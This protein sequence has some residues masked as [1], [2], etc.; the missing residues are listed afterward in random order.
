MPY[1]PTTALLESAVR[2]ASANVY[3]YRLNLSRQREYQRQLEEAKQVLQQ[4]RKQLDPAGY[5]AQQQWQQDQAAG[6]YY[7]S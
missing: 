2:A 1:N 3:A 7:H 5:H 4:H 6:H